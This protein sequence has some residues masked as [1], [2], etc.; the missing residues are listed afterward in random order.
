MIDFVWFPTLALPI[1]PSEKEMDIEMLLL[2]GLGHPFYWKLQT[3]PVGL[4]EKIMNDGPFYDSSDDPRN[5]W[6]EWYNYD[7]VE[8]FWQDPAIPDKAEYLRRSFFPRMGDEHEAKYGPGFFEQLDVYLDNLNNLISKDEV[9]AYLGKEDA[10]SFYAYLNVIK[11][12]KEKW[13]ENNNWPDGCTEEELAAF[14]GNIQNNDPNFDHARTLYGQDF[15]T[16]FSRVGGKAFRGTE[17]FDLIDPS[18]EATKEELYS[19]LDATHAVAG[20][21]LITD[22]NDRL[23]RENIFRGTEIEVLYRHRIKLWLCLLLKKTCEAYEEGKV[24]PEEKKGRKS[25]K[26]V[27][28]DQIRKSLQRF[29]EEEVDDYYYME[30]EDEGTANGSFAEEDDLVEEDAIDYEEEDEE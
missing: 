29:E 16:L 27:S 15:N 12:L 11:A 28:D 13:P 7:Y 25:K 5:W 14:I 22:G 8:E 6:R 21:N 9:T 10:E 18:L 2:G 30:D 3:L 4:T 1:D 17:S 23:E 19:Y 20:M 24:T 26:S